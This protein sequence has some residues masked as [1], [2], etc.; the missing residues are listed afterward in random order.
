MVNEILTQAGVP[1]RRTRFTSPPG[2]TYA[3]YVHDKSSG[4]AD[5]LHLLTE[6]SIT[7]NLYEPEPDDAAEE[8]ME[9]A[10]DAFGLPWNKQDRVWLPD[11]QRYQVTYTFTYTEKRRMNYG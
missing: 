6:S 10:I 7:V 2:G 4:G 11:E 5:G 1:Y 8:A 3:V 9:Q